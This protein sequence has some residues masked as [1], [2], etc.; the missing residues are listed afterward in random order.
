MLGADGQSD[1]SPRT[2]IDMSVSTPV[3]SA[4]TLLSTPVDR[5]LQSVSSPS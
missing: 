1:E 4:P 2:I 3:L 5:V